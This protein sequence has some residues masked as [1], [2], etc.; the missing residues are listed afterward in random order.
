MALSF[1]LPELRTACFRPTNLLDPAVSERQNDPLSR[2]FNAIF[3][4]PQRIFVRT[5][6]V[7]ESS[8]IAQTEVVYLVC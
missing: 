4:P 1:H 5:D 3:V 8:E 7:E 6:G 2:F